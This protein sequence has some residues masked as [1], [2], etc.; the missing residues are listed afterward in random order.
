MEG[1]KMPKGTL[2]AIMVAAQMLLAAGV[3]A[4][5]AAGAGIDTLDLTM[6]LMPESATLPDAITRVIELPAAVP[7]AARRNAAPGLEAAGA[8]GEGAERG[9]AIAAQARERGVDQAQEDRENAVRGPPITPGPPDGVPN[10]PPENL[11][12]PPEVPSGDSEG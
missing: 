8:A 11:P 1:K 7:E 2:F 10:G 3:R 6:E 4:Q 12:G 9:L 5:E